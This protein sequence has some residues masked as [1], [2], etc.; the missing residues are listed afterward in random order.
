[1]TK[2]KVITFSNIRFIVT[3]D[4]IWL[5]RESVMDMFG[6]GSGDYYVSPDCK[7][8]LDKDGKVISPV[9]G[10]VDHIELTEDIHGDAMQVHLINEAGIMQMEPSSWD[11]GGRSMDSFLKDEVISELHERQKYFMEVTTMENEMKVFENAEFGTVRTVLIEG[12][13]WMVGKDVAEILGYKDTKHAILD[14]VDEED[15][16]N[17]KARGQNA[18]ELG[19]RGSWLINES[20]VYSLI[21]SSK[22]PKAREFKRWVTSEVLPSIRK[23]GAYMTEETLEKALTSPDFL[24]RLATELKHEKE[25][26]LKA[27]ERIEIDRPKVQFANSVSGSPTSIPVGDLAKIMKQ[28]GVNIGQNRL[29]A[30]LRSNGWLMNTNESWNMPTQRGMNMGYFEIKEATCA[31]RCGVTRVYKKTMVTGKGQ[32]YF[33]DKMLT[34]KVA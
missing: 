29:F 32:I 8:V 30:W 13:P 22:M 7:F 12:E 23:H 16:V 24:I 27:E 3:Q 6:Y 1:M 31:D 2:S 9:V 11:C 21:L 15:R 4:N 20:G 5:V 10:L 25:A 19:Q 26:R 17:S 28:N 18:P 33:L 34:L 14:H